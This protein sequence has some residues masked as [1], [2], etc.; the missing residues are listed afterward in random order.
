MQ[1][2]H[3][4]PSRTDQWV[5]SS[6]IRGFPNQSLATRSSSQAW[7]LCQAFSGTAGWHPALI[8]NA[9][10]LDHSAWCSWTPHDHWT[11]NRAGVHQRTGPIISLHL[12]RRACWLSATDTVYSSSVESP[13]ECDYQRPELR[14]CGGN[15]G[16]LPLPSLCSDCTKRP[17]Y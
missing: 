9:A 4:V 5:L 12:T 15:C 8:E 11:P 17:D 6:V 2:F 14:A 7:L 10:R 1:L 13:S 16:R 3:P